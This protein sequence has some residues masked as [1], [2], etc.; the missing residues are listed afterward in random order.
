MIPSSEEPTL[1]RAALLSLGIIWPLGASFC[2]FM[3]GAHLSNTQVLWV[4][5]PVLGFPL[6]LLLA[7]SIHW[8]VAIRA[9]PPSSVSL[10]TGLSVFALAA[11]AA[12]AWV[13]SICALLWWF[14]NRW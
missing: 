12:V 4:S 7:A 10:L 3:L 1:L 14:P 13:T 6:V 8:L 5:V 11:A 2:L 9:A